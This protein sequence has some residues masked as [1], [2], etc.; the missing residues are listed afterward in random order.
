MMSQGFQEMPKETEW[1]RL[2]TYSPQLR[3]MKPIV[4]KDKYVKYQSWANRVVSTCVH[5][6]FSW[7]SLIKR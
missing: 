5:V 6:S 4:C 7:M 3:L 1:L 2:Q